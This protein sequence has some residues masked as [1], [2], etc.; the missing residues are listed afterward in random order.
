MPATADI[1]PL[2]ETLRPGDEPSVAHAVRDACERDVGV[3]PL[4]GRTQ[5]GLG[6]VPAEPGVGLDLRGLNRVVD[7]AADDMTITVEPGITMAELAEHLARRRQRLPIDVAE[8]DQAT[9]GG[10]IATNQAGPR[11]FGY[12]T[13]RDYVLGIR[14]VD[15]RGTVFAGGGRVV[16]NAAGYN[17]PRL[18]VGSLGTLGV[19]T[20]ATLMVRPVAST[21]AMIGCEIFE[22]AAADGLLDAL[23][24]S[25]VRPVSIDLVTAADVLP[26]EDRWPDA[27]VAGSTDRFGWLLIGFEGTRPEVQWMIET[28]HRDWAG[29]RDASEGAVV[30]LNADAARD[31]WSLLSRH[32]AHARVAV[33]PGRVT[34]AA[35]RCLAID[36]DA[37]LI[38]HAGDGIMH[39]EFSNRIDGW[40]RP[41]VREQL[42]PAIVELDGRVTITNIAGALANGETL[43]RDDVWGPPSDATE[44]MQAMKQRFDPHNILNRDRYVF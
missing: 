5:L 26:D 19:L 14:A 43:S 13:L 31:V 34:A 8:P 20:Q 11:R 22:L 12:G 10:L 27:L 1:L 36:P 15:G 4:G 16:K 21:A 33:R 38:V 41:T 29:D 32:D 2:R 17:V 7:H 37:S 3:Y 23:T 42:R 9:I 30:T 40:L 39:V 6:A 24:R 44:C 28:L 35:E 18:I 25:P